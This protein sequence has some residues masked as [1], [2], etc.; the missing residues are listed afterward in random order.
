[1]LLLLA[2]KSQ[3]EISLPLFIASLIFADI[4]EL[5]IHLLYWNIV[6]FAAGAANKSTINFLQYL[7]IIDFVCSLHASLNLFNFK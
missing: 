1:M 6:K 4:A 2:F 3:F 7:Q 5:S